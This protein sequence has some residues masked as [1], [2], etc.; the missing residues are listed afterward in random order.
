MRLTK[1][2]D[3]DQA[4]KS[5]ARQI[6]D[7]HPETQ[8]IVL[9]GIANGGIAFNNRLFDELKKLTNST[10]SKG[11]IDISFHRDD[12]GQKPILKDVE[13]TQIQQNP[14]DSLIILVDDVLFSGRTIRAA[15]AELHAIG[16]PSKVELAIL[17]DR[18]NR[19]LPIAA[20]YTGFTFETT[21]DENV[22]VYIDEENPTESKIEIK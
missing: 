12:F 8:S 11:T 10:L 17:V 16:R 18:G 19:R 14:E 2:A 7:N 22:D 6:A 20:D 5:I 21:L 9:A 15:M 1:S 13:P 3:I 4:I